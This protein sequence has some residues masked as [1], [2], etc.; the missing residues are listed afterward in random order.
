MRLCLQLHDAK[1]HIEE[2]TARSA[3]AQQGVER[4]LL[5]LRGEVTKHDAYDAYIV[6]EE[7]GVTTA[8]RTAVKATEV[9]L[10]LLP[11]VLRTISMMLL[12]FTAG[13]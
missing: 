5:C 11:K 7:D 1:A 12:R 9:N 2:I 10:S 3:V 8:S 4:V 13:A 6:V